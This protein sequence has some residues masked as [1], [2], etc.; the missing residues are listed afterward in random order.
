MNRPVGTQGTGG[1]APLADNFARDLTALLRSDLPARIGLAVSGGSD[2]VALMHLAADWAAGAGVQL[3]VVTVDHGLRPDAAAEAA[4]VA[5]Q[6]AALGLPHDTLRWQ[7]PDGTGNLMDRARRARY[8]LMSGWAATIGI[9]HIALGHT[10]DDVAETFLM[11]LG[12]EAGVD[13]LSAMASRKQR[14]ETQ[15]LR[16]L[17]SF[18]RNQLR[19][20][21]TA[22]K[23]QWVD[24]PSNDDTRFERVRARA[25]LAALEP[26]GIT[27]EGLARVSANLSEARRALNWYAFVAAREAIRIE[28]GDALIC[29]RQM[30]IMPGEIARRLLVHALCWVSGAEYAPRRR[31]VQ[32]LQTGMTAA[33]GMALHGCRAVYLTGEDRGILRICRD[34]RAVSDTR[35]APGQPW[36][37]RWLLDGPWPNGAEIR[38]T[39]AAG[40]AQLDNWR[41]AGLPEPAAQS[42]PAVWRGDL[43]I[44]S[45]LLGKSDGWTAIPAILG[46]EFFNALLVS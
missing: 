36:D 35:A 32:Q 45:P 9:D 37:R 16:P 24:D 43:L 39:G 11:R 6:A 19:D 10:A 26:L 1:F 15:F 33:H 4:G 30:R 12:R 13:G 8:D 46:E 3:H 23:V 18:Q 5:Q 42:A 7:T 22:R 21:L 27:P 25:V 2:S 29:L 41:D 31:A 40:L 38:A 28:Q 44:A 20:Y 17:L 14:A 34:P